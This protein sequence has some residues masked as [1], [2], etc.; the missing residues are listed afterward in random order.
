MSALAAARAIHF[1]ICIQAVGGSLFLG[2]VDRLPE[3]NGGRRW[4]LATTLI[5]AL[6][7]PPSGLVWLTLQAADMTD[8]NALQAWA[9]GAVATL[10]WQSQAGAVWWLRAA[11]ASALVAVTLMLALAPRPTGRWSVFLVFAIAAALFMSC[12]WLSHAASDPSPYRPLH[13][14]VHSLH[15][16][17]AAVWFG[18]LLPLAM[19]LALAEQS[20]AAADFTV[21]REAA[22]RFSVVALVAVGLIIASGIANLMLLVGSVADL[23]AGRFLQILGLKLV[24]FAAMLVLAAINRQVLVPRLAVLDPRRA[25]VLLRRSVWAEAALAALVILVIGELGITPPVPD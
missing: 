9:G 11:L 19:L 25:I 12:A 4:L 15:M 3:P 7:V 1:A 22:K 6:A 2:I 16:L 14:A 21:A 5:A 13:V 23:S 10:L 24:L 18:G 8:S 20:R 17:G